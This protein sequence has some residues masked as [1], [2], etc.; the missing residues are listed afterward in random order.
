VDNMHTA[1]TLRPYTANE[2]YS[3]SAHNIR[4]TT[5]AKLQASNNPS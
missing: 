3:S 1:A 4:I 2:Y 5:S